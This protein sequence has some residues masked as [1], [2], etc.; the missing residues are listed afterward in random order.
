MVGSVDE[1]EWTLAEM[2][3]MTRKEL[4]GRMGSDEFLSWK[5]LTEVRAA[6]RKKEEQQQRSRRGRG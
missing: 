2:L 3:G 5:A 1:D 6:R 4:L